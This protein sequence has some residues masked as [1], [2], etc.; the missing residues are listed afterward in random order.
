VQRSCTGGGG[1][2][3]LTYLNFDLPS[4]SVLQLTFCLAK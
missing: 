1:M 2:Y 3:W 4:G